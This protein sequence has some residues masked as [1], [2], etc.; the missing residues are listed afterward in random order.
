MRAKILF[1]LPIVAMAM[2]CAIGCGPNISETRMAYFPPKAEGCNLE[3]INKA[4][5]SGEN[6]ALPDSPYEIVGMIGLG[7]NGTQDPFSD[8]YMAIVR[9]RACKMGG[10]AISLMASQTTNQYITNATGTAYVVLHKRGE[11]AK[12]PARAPT[13]DL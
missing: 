8:R 5:A 12:S 1:F 7:E 3:V 2:T 11:P 10:D 13:A 9:P 4:L 6:F